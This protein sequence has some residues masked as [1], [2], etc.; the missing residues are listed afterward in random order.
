MSERVFFIT[1]G[2]PLATLLIIFA[3]KYFASIRQARS[4]TLTEEAYR[5]L[6]ERAIKAEEHSAQSL[7][8]IRADIAAI[9]DR[10]S[11]VEKMLKTVE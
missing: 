9:S 1:I 6:A 7:S 5:T 2:M 11:A 3:M 4:R 10:L 8:A